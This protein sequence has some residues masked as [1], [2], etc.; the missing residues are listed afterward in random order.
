MVRRCLDEVMLFYVAFRF[1]WY[2]AHLLLT[3][4]LWN[5]RSTL[6]RRMSYRSARNA[7]NVPK[8]SQTGESVPSLSSIPR[9]LLHICYRFSCLQNLSN[10]SVLCSAFRPMLVGTQIRTR[11]LHLFNSMSAQVG[12]PRCFPMLC[13]SFSTP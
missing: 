7:E 12:L 3:M 13:I 8:Y 1:D 4:P 5:A 2:Y 11:N 6:M 10:H 9:L